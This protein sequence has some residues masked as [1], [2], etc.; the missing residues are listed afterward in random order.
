MTDARD[1]ERLAV[2]LKICRDAGYV[3]EETATYL[4]ACG[5]TPAEAP[6]TAGW[7]AHNNVVACVLCKQPVQVTALNAIRC[8]KCVEAP[9]TAALRD[10]DAQWCKALLAVLDTKEIEIVLRWFNANRPDGVAFV[11]LG[12]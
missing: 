2:L 10:R 5:V 11:C 1:V 9:P 8:E 4:A 12:R 3:V 7:N 6:P